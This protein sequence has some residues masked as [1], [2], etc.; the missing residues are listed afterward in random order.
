MSFKDLEQKHNL[1]N[2]VILACGKH[3]ADADIN[4]LLEERLERFY[5]DAVIEGMAKKMRSSVDRAV[6]AMVKDWVS[7]R[8][9]LADG[10]AQP[11]QEPVAWMTNSEHEYSIEY[12]FNWLQTPLHD[13]P[14]YTAPPRKPWQGL[15]DDEIHKIID[16]CTSDEAEQEE[17]ND[18]AKAVRFAETKLKEKNNAV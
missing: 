9:G 8:Q 16:N 7:Y 11:E 13:I 17:L 15:T 4:P 2:K 12:K 3:P 18:F 6:N 5:V 1:V 14:L 10:A